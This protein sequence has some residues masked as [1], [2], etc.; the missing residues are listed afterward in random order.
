[1]EWLSLLGLLDRLPSVFYPFCRMIAFC[2]F[3][4]LLSEKSITLRLRVALALVISL[5]IALPS[6]SQPVSLFSSPGV[7]LIINQCVI[8]AA[9]G[10][11]MQ[12][13]FAAI[14]LA[15][16]VI[17]LQMGLSFAS[18]FDSGSHSSLSVVSRLLT[19]MSLLL[20][21]NID[22]I[23]WMI[24]HLADS[25]EQ[26]PYD[27]LTPLTGSFIDLAQLGGAIFSQ[28]LQLSIP[29][30]FMLLAV[31]LALGLLNRMTPQFSAFV[32]GFPLT[33]LIGI[34]SLYQSMPM[35]LDAIQA[36]L[37]NLSQQLLLIFSTR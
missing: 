22:G 7:L 37:L 27:T 26:L 33:L 23:V 28:A 14:R 2:S 4:P 21:V 32:I 12:F 35:L 19:Y 17:A 8:G 11:S 25:F 20:F 16:E 30:I 34:F 15:G 29:L 3:A 6:A 36:M 24:E 5:L 13:V 31:N 10:L 18:F 1:M 9:L